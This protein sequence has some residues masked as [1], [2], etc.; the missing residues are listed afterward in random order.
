MDPTVP[1]TAYAAAASY[2]RLANASASSFQSSA[3]E[4]PA[5]S[6]AGHQNTDPTQSTTNQLILQ[7]H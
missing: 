6:L 4:F 3:A 5:S 1:W 2:N 7:V